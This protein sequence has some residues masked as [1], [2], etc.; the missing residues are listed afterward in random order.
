MGEGGERIKREE[1]RSEE[2]K[3]RRRKERRC[4]KRAAWIA[5]L[6]FY[7]GLSG[8]QWKENEGLGFRQVSIQFPAPPLPRYNLEQITSPLLA[9]MLSSL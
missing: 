8:F 5:E 4:G 7:C 6:N 2:Q 9:T 3:K 1:R